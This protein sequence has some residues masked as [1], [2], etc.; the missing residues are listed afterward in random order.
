MSNPINEHQ[1]LFS[2]SGLKLG[3]ILYY[4]LDAHRQMD[5]KCRSSQELLRE[6]GKD[7]IYWW[8]Y[9][10][11]PDVH[12]L[13]GRVKQ[14]LVSAQT[15]KEASYGLDGSA[16]TSYS[17]LILALVKFAEDHQDQ[18]DDLLGFIKWLRDK[19][20]TAPSIMFTYRVWGSTRRSNRGLG[21]D[22]RELNED[23]PSWMVRLTEISFGLADKMGYHWDHF[24]ADISADMYD[25]DP[26]NYHHQEIP[27]E[28]IFVR[29]KDKVLKEFGVFFE[30]LRDSLRNIEL[31]IEKY[32]AEKNLLKSESFWRD[33]IAKARLPGRIES[34]LWD[35]K[36]TLEMWQVPSHMKPRAQI[37][38]C[39]TLAA[40]ANNLGGA[41]IIGIANDTREIVGVP[42]LENK[43]KNISEV[44]I[45]WIEY[46]QIEGIFHLQPVPYCADATGQTCLIVAIAQ[47]EEVT[48]VRGLSGEYY[49]PDRNE[50]GVTYPDK[51]VLVTRKTHLKA[52]DN[53]GF[54]RD[55]E[56]FVYDR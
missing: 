53:F 35:F 15:L 21:F 34:N 56:Q 18:I 17:E 48:S 27:E 29:T 14:V 31:D 8:I 55:L 26:E 24:I 42:D 2:D 20:P 28:R 7:E 44:I 1:R 43:I 51:R 10:K 30:E 37:N 54:M 22:L 41:I 5:A 45:R 52:G 12:E 36:E 40:F 46:P 47:T 32:L 39:K 11:E 13:Q 6:I 49:Y 16:I 23:D 50:T 38:F 9:K 19:D 33:F 25:A 3:R 4:L